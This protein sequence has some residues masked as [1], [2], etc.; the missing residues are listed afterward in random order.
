MN[1]QWGTKAGLVAA[2]LLA[3]LSVASASAATSRAS[4]TG[5]ALSGI[6]GSILINQTAGAGNQQSNRLSIGL[7]P[8]AAQPVSNSGL[9][10]T[11]GQPGGKLTKANANSHDKVSSSSGSF[12]DTTGIM[13]VN[14]SA[15]TNNQTRNH[16]AVSV[17]S[18]VRH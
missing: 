1:G 9:Q 8:D 5:Q 16:I 18:G 15:G 12:A 6:G 10:D 2:L 7:A 13:Q 14:Q 11:A 17:G 4:I 3:G